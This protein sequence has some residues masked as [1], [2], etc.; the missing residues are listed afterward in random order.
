[1]ILRV[2]YLD[3]IA[4]EKQRDVVYVTFYK[5]F[6]DYMEQSK[7][8]DPLSK[9]FETRKDRDDFIKFLED[10]N[11]GYKFCFGKYDS[12]VIMESYQGSLYVD[13]PYDV[14]NEEFKKVSEYLEYEDGT[15]KHEGIYFWYMR[16]EDA[17]LDEDRDYN[18]PDWN[19]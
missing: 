18:Q 15:R 9:E 8:C 7:G 17:T 3:D 4:I 16:L 2:P 6:W 14:N 10:N 13:V 12:C 5:D 19:P 11:I 1:M